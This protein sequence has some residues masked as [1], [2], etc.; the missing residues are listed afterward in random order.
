MMSIS[1][2]TLGSLPTMGKLGRSHGWKGFALSVTARRRRPPVNT[3]K[4]K[5][6]KA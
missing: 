5:N 6:F 4:H 2:K 1:D 3:Q